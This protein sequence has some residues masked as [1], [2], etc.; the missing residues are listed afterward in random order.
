MK[1][2]SPAS[3]QSSPDPYSL[4]K[5]PQ[6]PF[7]SLKT[8][9]LSLPQG[10]CTYCVL[11]LGHAPPPL[12]PR[13]MCHLFQEVYPDQHSQGCCYPPPSHQHMVLIIFITM[14]S[15]LKWWF[16]LLVYCWF[17]PLECDLHEGQDFVLI[18]VLSPV[19]RTVYHALQIYF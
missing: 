13:L 10:P 11:Q 5:P 6:L 19:P 3:S 1:S 18:R 14:L 8:R 2:E 7:C 16:S 12:R 15:C 17:S 4:R 9:S